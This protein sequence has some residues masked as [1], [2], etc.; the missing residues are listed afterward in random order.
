MRT[1]PGL[2]KR[3]CG[4]FM[5]SLE[6]DPHALCPLC[7]GQRC[8]K[9]N[10]CTFGGKGGASGV[11]FQRHLFEGPMTLT[12]YPGVAFVALS[13]SEEKSP[14]LV[15]A[16]E[17]L[18]AVERRSSSPHQL[19]PVRQRSLVHRHSPARQRALH[20]EDDQCSPT[21]QRS[22]SRQ[23]LSGR[24]LQPHSPSRQSSP[25]R[26]LSFGHPQP[27]KQQLPDGCTA[28][29]HSPARA[30]KHALVPV[31]VARSLRP[32][33]PAPSRSSDSDTPRLSGQHGVGPAGCEEGASPTCAPIADRSARHQLREIKSSRRHLSPSHHHQRSPKRSRGHSP[34]PSLECS[35]THSYARSPA[36]SRAYS[37]VHHSP[38]RSHA[39]APA[40]A[41]HPSRLYD[42]LS[43]TRERSPTGRSPTRYRATSPA[44]E[45]VFTSSPGRDEFIS[46][47][48]DSSDSENSPLAPRGEFSP[49]RGEVAREEVPPRASV[50]ESYFPSRRESKDT[51]TIPKSSSRFRQEPAIPREDVHVSPQEGLLG[52]GD[53]AAS[54][55]KGEHRERKDSKAE[56]GSR[57]FPQTR[58]ASGLTVVMSLRPSII[59]G[60]SCSKWPP[61]DEIPSVAAEVAMESGK[62]FPGLPSSHRT[63]E[64]GGPSMAA[65]L[66]LSSPGPQGFL[67]GCLSTQVGQHGRLRLPTFLS[68]EKA[69]KSVKFIRWVKNI[70]QVKTQ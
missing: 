10:V 49:D 66:L 20:L 23:R 70:I 31:P 32:R 5:S 17:R 11:S 43:P 46:S 34:A 56:E 48:G 64:T 69:S 29:H 22:P 26:Q 24:A 39:R 41:R 6:T 42:H 45:T 15:R 36:Q 65:P 13:P 7:R 58:R 28:H 57:T 51:K 12:P 52:M 63:F 54:P 18:R 50:L 60:P 16:P 9:E 53:L 21:H 37:P 8:D 35:P 55:P 2:P 59:F 68:D 62:R 14:A 67:A 4:T 47:S 38:A 33:S 30:R 44:R 1:C 40:H 25:A 19:S 27:E 3:S 61:Q